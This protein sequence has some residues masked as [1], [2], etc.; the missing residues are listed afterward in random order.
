MATASVNS[1]T[2]HAGDC[3]RKIMNF[4]DNLFA[5]NAAALKEN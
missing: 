1:L 3:V 4:I 5:F 2:I